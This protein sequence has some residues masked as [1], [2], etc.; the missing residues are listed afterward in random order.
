MH[1]WVFDVRTISCGLGASIYAHGLYQCQS[2]TQIF[3]RGASKS[4]P[5]SVVEMAWW[6]SH[7]PYP[8]LFLWRLSN[9]LL[10]CG[11]DGWFRNHPQSKLLSL[12]HSKEASL[13]TILWPR[14]SAD[15]PNLDQKVFWRA[16]LADMYLIHS[17]LRCCQSCLLCLEWMLMLGFIS[18]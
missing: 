6:Q 17:T 11:V 7:I 16:M 18:H 13:D 9:T 14:I 12:N 2:V 8:H 10:M 15:L 3:S 5:T 1:M 4:G